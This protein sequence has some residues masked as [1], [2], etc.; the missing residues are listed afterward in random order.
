MDAEFRILDYNA[1]GHFSYS[2]DYN[3]HLNGNSL[4]LLHTHHSVDSLESRPLYWPDFTTFIEKPEIDIN[5]LIE[6]GL[7]RLKARLCIFLLKNR[8]LFDEGTSYISDQ[9]HDVGT[10]NWK[11]GD[12]IDRYYSLAAW[13]F[14]E[15]D[16]GTEDFQLERNI[17]EL[18]EMGRLHLPKKKAH[19]FKGDE[20]NFQGLFDE[21][22]EHLKYIKQVYTSNQK[23][24]YAH[25]LHD[26]Q[27]TLYLFFKK[28]PL[29]DKNLSQEVLHMLG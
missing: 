29:Y 21:L 24:I 23:V 11:R 25:G 26:P 17:C 28:N 14:E 12:L 2:L 4:H 1:F 9:W 27:S 22:S 3:A 13:V 19:T 7:P 18:I 6:E 20:S 10:G 5:T 15:S 8:K 16:Q